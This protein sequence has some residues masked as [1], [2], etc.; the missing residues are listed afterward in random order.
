MTTLACQV[1][2]IGAGPYALAAAAHLR[3]AK[4]DICMFGKSM[5]FWERQMPAGMLLRSGWEGSHIDDPH[6]GLTLDRYQ[7][8]RGIQLPRPI[9]VQD[10][11]D[12]G[13]WFQRQVVPDLDTRH[14]TRLEATPGEFQIT[15][16]DGE[17][18][19]AQRVIIATGIGS[20]A[21]RPRQFDT[22]SRAFAS[23]SSEHCD[24]ARFKGQNVVVVGGGQSALESAALLHESGA[25][26]EVVV[27]S[28]RIHWLRYGTPL[29]TWLHRPTNIL[30]RILYPPSEIGPFGLNWIVHIPPVLRSFPSALRPRMER[31][32]I[33][34]AGAGW[35]A[36]RLTGVTI[37]TGRVVVSASSVGQQLRLKLDDGSERY[38]DHALLATGYRVDISRCAF[39]APHLLRSLRLV[40][41]YP[42]L[43]AGF[44]ASLP[45]LHFLGASAAGTFGPLMRFVA[46]TKY[47]ARALTRGILGQATDPVT[48]KDASYERDEL[49]KPS[50]G[51]H[52]S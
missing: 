13:R 11:V 7:K 15:L 34:P 51:V 48:S 47:A 18:V 19:S 31:R 5:D 9:R 45:G 36:P 4:V 1:A 39:L 43:S 44:E 17:A 52:T 27:R 38:A 41:G 46:G 37:T 3:A 28:R 16:Q 2:I 33:R 10:F 20:F 32:A 22:L 40:D 8:A 49:H 6:G 23:H 26:V 12:Y 35:L 24:L 42:E 29:H 25:T 30:G 14:V 21:Y 50:M